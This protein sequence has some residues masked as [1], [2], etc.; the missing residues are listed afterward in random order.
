MYAIRSYYAITFAM[1]LSQQAPL[2]LR[3][4][5]QLLAEA[6]DGDLEK[7]IDREAVLQNTAV[8]SKDFAEGAQA[9]IEKRQPVFTGN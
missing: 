1:Q 8:R 3:F 9:F 4:S 2:T 5:K 7:I 6:A